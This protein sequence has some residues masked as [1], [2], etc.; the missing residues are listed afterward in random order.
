MRARALNAVFPA[1]SLYG[2]SGTPDGGA[3]SS[4]PLRPMTGRVGRSSSRHQ[5]T[6]VRS[7]KVQT[8]AIPVP[9]SGSASRCASTGTSTE[10]S[11]VR[12]V[13]PNSGWYRASSGCATR[14]TQA[15][16]S[17]GRVVSIHTGPF[18]PWKE[19]L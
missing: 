11:G 3:G 18:G 13:R 7:P 14:A 2:D 10:K 9:L 19:I 15:G 16:M 1:S 17:S 4:R 8:M 6:S 12:T 5:I